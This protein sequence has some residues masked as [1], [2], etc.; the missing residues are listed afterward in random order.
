[1]SIST[2][3]SRSEADEIDNASSLRNP[4][5]ELHKTEADIDLTA[6]NADGSPYN[7]QP[8]PANLTDNPLYYLANTELDY[9]R[10]R[11]LGSITAQ[12]NPVEWFD[13]EAN[14]SLDR[15]KID[16]LEYYKKGYL[17][18][19]YVGI[20]QGQITRENGTNNALNAG[21][22]AGFR[23]SFGALNMRT[24]LR[25]LYEK[26][27]FNFVSAQG[28]NLTVEG[29]KDLDNVQGD[30][31][32]TSLE[33]TMKAEGFYL[34]NAFEYKD[35]YI[36]DFL[37]RRDGSSLFGSDQ[38]YHTYFRFSGAWRIS[39][40][41]FWPI[42]NYL[43]EFKLHY[44][45]GTAGN[46]PNFFAQYETY[47]V[48]S[49]SVSKTNLGNKDLMPEQATEHEFGIS[50]AFFN[51][52]SLEMN[53]SKSTVDNQ[54][55]LVPLP[56][57]KGFGSQWKNAGKV[58]SNSFEATLEGLAFRS[59]EQSISFGATFDRVR[60][61]IVRLDVP[62]YKYGFGQ[63]ADQFYVKE[64]EDIGTVYGRKWVHNIGELRENWQPY[65]NQFQVNDEGYLVWVGEGNSWTDGISKDLWGT[66]G[67]L[68]GD[69]RNDVLWG[70]PLRYQEG[71]GNNYVRLGRTTPDYNLGFNTTYRWKGFSMYM[72][73]NA[74][75]GGIVYNLNK[76]WM[77]TANTHADMD[78]AGK[79]E[80]EKK[81]MDYYNSFSA[82]LTPD[83]RFAEEGTFYKLRELSIAY[84]FGAQQLSP[85]FG[86]L[87][88]RITLKLIGRNL[89]TFSDYDGYDPEVGIRGDDSGSSVIGR[90]D[91]DVTY[92]HYRTYTFS[93][94]LE[95]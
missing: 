24:K 73:W 31:Q 57:Y 32:L 34:I 5:E 20:D 26:Y 47:S 25:Y 59:G 67:D 3:Y 79:S 35:R 87:F 56:A 39:E 81:T 6:P 85:V 17:S 58:E 14:M 65:A 83:E 23:K 61:E 60:S 74:Q 52:V 38:R 76:Q 68:D 70:Q 49:G 8:D 86:H 78:Q 88:N 22:T 95:F 27:D 51:R 50:S 10:E 66:S 29:I 43:N 93:V 69:G 54:I 75:V 64:G 55:L 72:L 92:P 40:E 89:L 15:L 63:N 62:P 82:G 45:L 91:D 71:N 11:L 36:T 16:N 77:Y 9:K 80:G 42:K 28:K 7:Y 13:L 4:L 2:Q 53:Y 94:G 1:M 21:I 30:I 12:Y 48:E 19:Y 37:V 41:P 90:I 33:T 18:S 46:R 44:S 84:S